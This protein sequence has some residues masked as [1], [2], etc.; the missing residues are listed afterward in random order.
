MPG[1]LEGSPALTFAPLDIRPDHAAA[2][3][4]SRAMMERRYEAYK[5]HVVRPFFRDHFARLDRQIVLVDVLAALN[6][7]PAALRDLEGALADDPRRLP[8][9]PASWLTLHPDAAHRPHPLRRDQGRPP[10]PQRPRPAGERSWRGWSRS[11]VERA[12]FA[13]AAGRVVP[14]AAVRATREAT[15]KRGGERLPASSACRCRASG[16][17]A[18][19]IDGETE[20]ALFPGDLPDDPEAV[21]EA[22]G[23]PTSGSSPR[24][25]SPRVSCASG[26][27]GWSARP[28]ASRCRCRTSASTGRSNS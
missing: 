6:A 27:R 10:P 17:T 9:R 3:A 21:F 26:R 14:L 16:W 7:G 18:R 20:I 4:R 22:R 11:A 23:R 8:P 24:R 28:R 5:T 13:G 15:V 19:S 12:E 25:R 2:R 1:D